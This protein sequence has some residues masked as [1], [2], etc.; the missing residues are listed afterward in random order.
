MRYVAFLRAINVGG[1]VVKMERLRSIF[2]ALRFTDVA[3]FIASGNVIFESDARADE[4]EEKIEGRL[5]GELGFSSEAFVRTFDEIKA[6]VELSSVPA[7]ANLYVGFLKRKPD[8]PAI[9]AATALSSDIDAIRVTGRELYW[10]SQKSTGT[11]KLTGAAIERAMAM[12][13][14]LRNV[15]SLRKLLAAHSR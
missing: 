4:I 2:E 5:S 9:A 15:T 6:A 3:T 8:T 7:G 13:M 12:P 14:T 1:R 11:S 10:L